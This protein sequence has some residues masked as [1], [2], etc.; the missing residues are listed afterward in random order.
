MPAPHA[1]IFFSRNNLTGVVSG[2]KRKENMVRSILIST[3]VLAMAIGSGSVLGQEAPP[4]PSRSVEKSN[5]PL[6]IADLSVAKDS[7][8]IGKLLPVLKE[9]APGFEYVVEPGSWE[10]AVVPEMKLQ[11]VTIPQVISILATF[12]PNFTFTTIN[13]G[14]EFP[15]KRP[16]VYIFKNRTSEA[17]ADIRV[18]AFGVS[19]IA[20]HLAARV[21]GTA[22]RAK[23]Q[24]ARQDTLQHVLSLIE[25][26]LS[27]AAAPGIKPVVGF[28]AETETVILKATNQQI[29][30]V[31]QTLDTLQPLANYD[32]LNDQLRETRAQVDSLH[33]ELLKRDSEIAELKVRL[34]AAQRKNEADSKH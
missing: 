26:T 34:E 8:T 27:Q 7:M 20:D 5:D 16:P 25:N 33:G 10:D 6:L 11:D 29:N 13:G 21:D 31:K 14:A 2:V 9:K 30:A 15:P 24:K 18:Q 1:G 23:Y 28:H 22:D 3:A 12:S 19:G 17:N 32:R 4:P